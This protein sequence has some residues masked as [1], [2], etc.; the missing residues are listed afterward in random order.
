MFFL[1]DIPLA[2]LPSVPGHAV[3]V[4]SPTSQAKAVTENASS[5]APPRQKSQAEDE[6]DKECLQKFLKMP[7]RRVIEE[8]ESEGAADSEV[9]VNVKNEK[10]KRETFIVG[11]MS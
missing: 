10:F 2:T 1:Q 5:T 4:T 6:S 8:D 7:V 9:S 3:Q 11:E